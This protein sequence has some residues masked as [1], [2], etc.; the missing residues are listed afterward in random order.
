[1]KPALGL[2][3][4]ISLVLTAVALSAEPKAFR[5][6]GTIQRVSADRLLVRTAA[7]DIEIMRDAKTKITGE[8][9]RGAAATVFYHDVAGAPYAT[10]IVMGG[11]PKPK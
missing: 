5:A 6:D 7:Q 9:R 11:A 2:A 3:V 8:L 1:M 4:V 10:E